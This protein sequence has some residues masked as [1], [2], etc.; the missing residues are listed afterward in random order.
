[1]KDL[2]LHTVDIREKVFKRLGVKQKIIAG[3]DDFVTFND[4][5]GHT[6][7]NENL[8]LYNVSINTNCQNQLVNVL[9]GKS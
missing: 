6:L 2:C 8:R 1:M 9:E 5:W 7:F 4:L 3:K